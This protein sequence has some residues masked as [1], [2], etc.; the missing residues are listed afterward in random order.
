MRR[1]TFIFTCGDTNGIGP[2]I[3]LRSIN[4]LFIK[5]KN[6][7]ILTIPKNVFE[8][9]HGLLSIDFPYKIVNSKEE[10]NKS[11][12]HVTIFD[13]GDV[14]ISCGKPTRFS[15]RASYKSVIEAHNMINLGLSSAMIT[16]PISKIAWQ[17][18]GIKYP[19][20]TVV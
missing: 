2:E 3:A 7:F 16:A 11:G 8:K 5:Y 4:K 15:G 14:D 17:K 9:Y 20:H 18:A 12:G 13:I 6:K 10:I 19:G 1:H